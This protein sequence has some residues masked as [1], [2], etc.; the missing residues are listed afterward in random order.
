M[1]HSNIKTTSIYYIK[2]NEFEP[3]GIKIGMCKVCEKGHLIKK[4]KLMP[5]RYLPP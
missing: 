4:D 5:L 2:N 3:T 1:G